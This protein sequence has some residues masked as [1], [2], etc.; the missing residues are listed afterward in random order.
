MTLLKNRGVVAPEASLTILAIP[1][2]SPA[3]LRLYDRC[4][5]DGEVFIQN[6]QIGSYY[7]VGENEGY[8]CSTGRA[9]KHPGTVRPLHVQ[10]IEGDLAMDKCLQDIYFLTALAWTRPEDCTRLPITI[11][12][13]DRALGDEATRYDQD[14]L[15]SYDPDENDDEESDEDSNEN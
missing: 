10:R 7:L 9:F 3:P 15:R 14:A 2:Q 5:R 4:D 12:L 1:K 6:P 8:L 13:N 11:K